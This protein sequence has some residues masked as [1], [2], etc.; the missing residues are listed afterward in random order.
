MRSIAI[1]AAPLP[2]LKG[3]PV[4]SCRVSFLTSM[5]NAETSPEPRFATNRNL[6]TES[7]ITADG[8]VPVADGDPLKGLSI[9]DASHA[10]PSTVFVPAFVT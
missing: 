10:N 2:V 1:A 3:L 9:P 5:A 6:P 7:M 4:T 8:L